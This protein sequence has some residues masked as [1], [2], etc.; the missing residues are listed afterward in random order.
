MRLT[1]LRHGITTDNIAHRFN[2]H[3]NDSLTSE[4]AVELARIRF[5]HSPYDLMYSSPLRRCIETARCL[6]IETFVEDA[7]LMERNLGIFEGLTNAECEER[8]AEAFAA[9]RKFDSDYRIP[10]GESRAEHLARTLSWLD[11]IAVNSN[12]L[13]IAH[14]GTLDFLYRMATG[15]ALHGPGGGFGIFGTAN[16]TLSVFEINGASV[17]LIEWGTPLRR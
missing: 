8:H 16:A 12:V 2:G 1:C 17:E 7:R 9:F 11:D 6:G 5:D 10:G 13:A 3:R 4:Q 14:G 15:H